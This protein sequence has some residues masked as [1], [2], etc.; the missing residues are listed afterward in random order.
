MES[1][2]IKSKHVSPGGRY[3]LSFKKKVVQEYE[4]GFLNKDQLQAK[5]GLGGNSVILQWCRKYGK[6]HH[7]EKGAL[8]RPMKDPQK[9]RIKDLEKQLEEAKL[10]LVAYE[11]LIEIAEK[12]D[13]INILKKDG[14]KQS[15]SLPKC[16]QEK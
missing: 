7:P 4:R 3:S 8:G 13:G 16:I 12:E 2:R 14:A 5:Y 1:Q 9:Q 10:K 11:K 15:V 6:L